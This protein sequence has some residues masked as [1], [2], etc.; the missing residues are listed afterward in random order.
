MGLIVAGYLSFGP[1]S[2]LFQSGWVI[3]LLV[4]SLVLVGLYLYS[5]DIEASFKRLLRTSVSPIIEESHRTSLVLSNRFEATEK[6]LENFAGAIHLYARHLASHT[7][8]IQGLSGASQALKGSAAEQNRILSQ[9]TNA[10]VQ[11]RSQEEISKIQR[12]VYNIEQRTRERLQVRDA[13]EKEV[14]V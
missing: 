4:V 8:A 11:Q 10:F 12:V 7:S 5:D 3:A 6:A 1:L 2:S 9:F 14:P 13:L